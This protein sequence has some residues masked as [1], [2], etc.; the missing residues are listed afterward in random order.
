VAGRPELGDPASPSESDSVSGGSGASVSSSGL[1]VPSPTAAVGMPHGE[2]AA[3]L[4]TPPACTW[5]ATYCPW[6]VGVS[7][8][9]GSQYRAAGAVAVVVPD[10]SVPDGVVVVLVAVVGGV[11][12]FS[13]T[14]VGVVPS[15]GLLEAVVSMVPTES[16]PLVAV[17]AA[18]APD[19]RI[20]APASASP[21]QRNVDSG[22]LIHT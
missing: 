19:P 4:G 20:N 2:C 12:L 11:V 22:F 5:L 15:V 1:V 21:L 3:S 13:G 7:P 18:A 14:V 6:F 16:A 8:Q 9:L 10:W 17:T